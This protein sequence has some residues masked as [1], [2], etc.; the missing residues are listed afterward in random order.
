MNKIIVSFCIATFQRCEV[1]KELVEEILSIQT[2]KLEIV[3]CDNNSADDTV[4]EL[5]KISD[6]RLKIYVN[7]RNVGSL[8]NMYEALEKGT[9]EYL[10]YINY[11][12]NL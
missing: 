5:K 12:D 11:R 8:L 9:G 6:V 7:E 10:F 4:K 3:V 1:V 2:D